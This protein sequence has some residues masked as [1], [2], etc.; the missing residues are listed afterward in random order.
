MRGDWILLFMIVSLCFYGLS[1]FEAP[2][3]AAKPPD[4][5][6]QY[7]GWLL[8]HVQSG[9]L[10]WV[11]LM[12]IGALYQLLPQ[13]FGREQMY[14]TKLIDA[15]FWLATSGM[16]LYT[17]SLW[18]AGLVQRAL[19]EDGVSSLELVDGITPLPFRLARL[20]GGVLFCTGMWIMAHNVWMTIRGAQ[21]V[22]VPVTAPEPELTPT[23]AATAAVRA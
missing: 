22:A 10:G 8:G 11:A 13:L 14:S 6:P 9:M 7:A 1:S 3:M 21:P 5:L 12:A 15:H 23:P 18:I 16:L 2:M 17:A 19:V 20:L 4:G